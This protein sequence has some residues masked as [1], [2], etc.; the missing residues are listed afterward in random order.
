[1]APAV[2]FQATLKAP[3]TEQQR[4]EVSTFALRHGLTMAEVIR[5]AVARYI[6]K[7]RP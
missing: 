2:R 6:A 4:D 3:T 5:R 7:G 1:M